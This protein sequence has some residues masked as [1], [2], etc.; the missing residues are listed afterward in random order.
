M[1]VTPEMCR[2]AS[3][4]KKLKITKFDGNFDV[5][6]DFDVKTQSNFNEDEVVSSTIECT[7]GQIKSYTFETLMQRVS[8][9]CN[10]G[11]KEA[12]IRVRKKVLCFL[13]EGRCSTTALASFAFIQDTP[14]NCVT[15][16][17]FSQDAT[18]LPYPLTADQKENQFFFLIE[19][20]DTGKGM[21][22]KL[23]SFS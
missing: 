11:I 15:T 9:S 6:V 19:F 14:K 3:K 22:K 8:L 4:P 17:I 18:L 21:N 12:S 1:I 7:G 23:K 16:K 2:L 10:N 5:P 13:M 20:N